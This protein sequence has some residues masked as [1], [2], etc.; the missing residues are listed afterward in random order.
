MTRRFMCPP[1]TGPSKAS[2]FATIFFYAA[3]RRDFLRNIAA[4]NVSHFFVPSRFSG[5]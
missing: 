4:T 1:Y 3:L 2:R 5:M